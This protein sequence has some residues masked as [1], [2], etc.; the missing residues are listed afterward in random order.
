[1]TP[2]ILLPVAGVMAMA[3]PPETPRITVVQAQID[4]GAQ[5]PKSVHVYAFRLR[6]E[7]M[8]SVA[9]LEVQPDCGC[10]VVEG[11]PRLMSPGEEIDVKARM[12]LPPHEGYVRK[13]LR[14]KTSDPE[15]PTLNLAMAATVVHFVRVK[16]CSLD[17]LDLRRGL[18]QRLALTLEADRALQTRLENA[19]RPWLDW[20]IERES[21]RKEQ[22]ILEVDT[23]KL[24]EKGTQGRETLRIHTGVAAQPTAEVELN[25]A[26]APLLKVEPKVV[27]LGGKGPHKARV[28]VW[29]EDGTPFRIED[30]EFDGEKL[31]CCSETPLSEELREAIIEVTLARPPAQEHEVHD[32]RIKTDRPG[33][34]DLWIRVLVR[35][36]D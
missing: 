35:G 22:L 32:L 16:P 17:L 31:S 21:P 36:R 9:I 5:P 29:S 4:M 2:W 7:T 33:E 13:G 34:T 23:F 15:S 12:T 10:T 28:K 27:D 20:F 26:F 19:G 3:T 11:G 25:W 14:V 8:R 30:L 24:W 1:M 18:P 6:N